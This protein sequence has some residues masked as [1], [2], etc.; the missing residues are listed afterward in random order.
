MKSSYFKLVNDKLNQRVV[1][2]KNYIEI[3]NCPKEPVNATLDSDENSNAISFQYHW[4]ASQLN[5]DSLT[6][7]FKDPIDFLSLTYSPQSE[8]EE[9]I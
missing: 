1:N 8:Y 7:T 3:T 6:F 9:L 4:N 2:D 5:L